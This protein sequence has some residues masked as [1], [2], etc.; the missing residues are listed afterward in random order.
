MACI[1]AGCTGCCWG[2]KSRHSAS[3]EQP[4]SLLTT[5]TRSALCKGLGV[6]G[7]DNDQCW[8]RTSVVGFLIVVVVGLAGFTPAAK[9]C[10]VSRLTFRA[11]RR[12]AIAC[13]LTTPYTIS[14]INTRFRGHSR[15][16]L[17]R[18]RVVV[19]RAH[20]RLRESCA[21]QLFSHIKL[22]CF[23]HAYHYTPN[24]V[25]SAETL[26]VHVSSLENSHASGTGRRVGSGT[27][28]YPST[29]AWC[30]RSR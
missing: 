6:Q 4:I 9:K 23:S 30:S 18:R 8:C 19:R 20:I 29:R 12:I 3:R 28:V 26:T 15:E 11:R 24:H 17:P 2:L 5:S 7:A 1:A 21:K 10:C 14:D 22:N 25:V 16:P 13:L 27:K